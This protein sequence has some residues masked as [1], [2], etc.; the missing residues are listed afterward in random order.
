[1]KS[2]KAIAILI[3]LIAAGCSTTK[4]VA[5]IALKPCVDDLKRE[6]L[7]P[8]VIPPVLSDGSTFLD[9]INQNAELRQ[10]LKVCSIKTR[11]L[12]GVLQNCKAVINQ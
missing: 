7:E 1:M 4:V 6:Y 8:C 2:F 3:P 9:A 12:Q 11:T 10:Q 5:P